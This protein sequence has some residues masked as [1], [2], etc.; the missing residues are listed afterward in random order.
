MVTINGW[1]VIVLETT[2]TILSDKESLR[3]IIIVHRYVEMACFVLLG[4]KNCVTCTLPFALTDLCQFTTET[5]ESVTL[6]AF[7]RFSTIENNAIIVWKTGSIVHNLCNVRWD[8][9]FV[10]SY[11]WRSDVWTKP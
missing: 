2:P 7:P 6:P 9:L 8:P 5:N 10:I 3:G 11:R 1:V 4:W